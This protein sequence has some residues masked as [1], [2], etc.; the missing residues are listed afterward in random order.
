MPM[1][2][3]AK[4]LMLLQSGVSLATVVLVIARAVNVFK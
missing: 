3:W 4:L 2:R 1:T